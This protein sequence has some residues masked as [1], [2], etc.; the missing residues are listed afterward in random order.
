MFKIVLRGKEGKESLYLT[1][2]KISRKTGHLITKMCSHGA[3]KKF[4][5][6]E[7]AVSVL[8]MIASGNNLDIGSM[9][10]RVEHAGIV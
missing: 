4:A 8:N 3:P 1:S 9:D 2:F 6:K 5:T 7:L 10:M